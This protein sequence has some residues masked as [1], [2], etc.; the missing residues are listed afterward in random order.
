MLKSCQNK[1]NFVMIKSCQNRWIY[2]KCSP[3]TTTTTKS[4]LRPLH[5]VTRGQKVVAIWKLWRFE[6]ETELFDLE[7]VNWNYFKLSNTFISWSFT[8]YWGSQNSSTSCL[9]NIANL[10]WNCLKPTF[11]FTVKPRNKTPSISMVCLVKA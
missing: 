5:F 10:K 9:L 4:F 6:A 7:I 11:D 8:T 2:R 1:S 3:T